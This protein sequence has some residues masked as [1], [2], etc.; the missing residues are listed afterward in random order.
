MSIM[1]LALLGGLLGA[2]LA[3]GPAHASDHKGLPAQFARDVYHHSASHV[4]FHPPQAMLRAVIVMRIRLGQDG[5]WKPEVMRE[6]A[7]Q[8]QLTLRALR[9][10]SLVPPPTDLT[11]DEKSTL[12]NEGFVET[13]LFEDDGRFALR[14]LALPQ[15]DGLRPV[16]GESRR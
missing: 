4:H 9:S 11:A 3:V 16:G 10:V 6:N 1:K 13:W 2:A 8:P 15:H 5:R 14:T 7:A 12:R